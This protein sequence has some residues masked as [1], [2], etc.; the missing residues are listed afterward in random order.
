MHFVYVIGLERGDGPLKIGIAEHIRSRLSGLNTSSP[1]RFC[2]RAAWSA[3]NVQ[4]TTDAEY[5]AHAVLADQRAH[6]EWFNCSIPE[7]IAAV[8][9]SPDLTRISIKRALGPRPLYAARMR[10]Q[11]NSARKAKRGSVFPVIIG[12]QTRSLDSLPR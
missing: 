9:T 7:A 10:K 6:G 8:E 5:A 2:V 3:R 4:T 1:F 12:I 11:E